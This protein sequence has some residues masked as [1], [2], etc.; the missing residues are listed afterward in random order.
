MIRV[1]KQLTE[2]ILLL[3]Q[4]H[5]YGDGAY[6]KSREL[7]GDLHASQDS[8][9]KT[10]RLLVQGGMVESSSNKNGGFRLSRPFADITMADVISAVKKYSHLP[11]LD[12]TISASL[13]PQTINRLELND[14][15]LRMVLHKCEQ[16]LLEEF[17][18]VTLASLHTDESKKRPTGLSESTL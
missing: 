5:A 7:A 16:T 8:L 12:E 4:L 1:S 17:A 11:T 13:D 15:Q 14:V 3:F 2:S 9:A 10:L 18:K 6:H